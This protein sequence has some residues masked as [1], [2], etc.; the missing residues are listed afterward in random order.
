MEML[1]QT[2]RM[3]PEAFIERIKKQSYIDSNVLFQALEEPSPVTIR[4]NR[5]KWNHIPSDAEPVPW[6][7]DG[8]YLKQRPSFTLDPFFHAGAYYPQEASGMFLEQIFAQIIE[9]QPYIKVLDLCGAPGGKSTHLSSLLGNKGILVANE[10][11]RSRSNILVENMVKWGWP[12]SVVS[13]SDPSVFSRLTGFFDLILVDAPCS[14]EGMFR[15]KTAVREWSEENAEMCA[16]RQK[17]ILMD[18]WPALKG[19]GILIY[20]TCTFNPAENEHNIRWLNSRHECDSIRLDISGFKDITEI[21]YQGI[22]GYGFYPGKIRGE[23]LFISVLKKTAKQEEI[24]T[25]NKFSHSGRLSRE[26]KATAEKWTLFGDDQLFTS[27]DSVIAL[28]GKRGD[29]HLL[30]ENLKLVR[31]G[32]KLFMKKADKY[33][34]YHDLAMAIKLKDESFPAVETDYDQALSY[35]RRGPFTPASLK[36]GWNIVGYKGVSLGFVNNIGSR[37][38]NYYPVNWRIR[39]DKPHKGKENL[40]NWLS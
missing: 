36:K 6:C 15:D 33:I 2:E 5:G 40:I 24:I 3:L 27:G 10:V 1:N 17:R 30:S 18:V 16:E 37:I 28:P 23:G 9:N 12:N 19:N 35:L 29:Y 31:S 32:V 13:Q 14:G 25:G 39:M 11:I 8:F 20:S 4:I 21:E 38:N 7:K 22:Y 34:P 26:L